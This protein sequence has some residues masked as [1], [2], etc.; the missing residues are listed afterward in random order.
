MK[1]VGNFLVRCDQEEGEKIEE[2]PQTEPFIFPGFGIPGLG[3][4]FGNFYN[5]PFRCR[6]MFPGYYA[7]I[8]RDCRVKQNTFFHKWFKPISSKIPFFCHNL[9]LSR[10]VGFFLKRQSTIQCIAQECKIRQ[11]HLFMSL[12]KVNLEEDNITCNV[13]QGV[14]S[15]NGLLCVT[16]GNDRL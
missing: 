10:L 3:I 2:T 8:D 13:D 7:D 12:L 5:G 9:E 16:M 11:F 1:L 4:G 14:I 15:T 6:N